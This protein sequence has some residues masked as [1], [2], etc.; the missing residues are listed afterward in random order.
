MR[1]TTRI[2][3]VGATSLVLGFVVAL[4]AL[5]AAPADAISENSQGDPPQVE[6][7]DLI[8]LDKFEFSDAGSGSFDNGTTGPDQDASEDGYQYTSS[9]G[10]TVAYDVDEDNETHSVTWWITADDPAVDLVVLKAGKNTPNKPVFYDEARGPETETVEGNAFSHITFCYDIEDPS[11]ELTHECVEG[12]SRITVTIT[13]PD[14]VGFEYDIEINDVVVATI[15]EAG[16]TTYDGADGDLLEVVND[17]QVLDELAFEDCSTPEEPEPT[18]ELSTACDDTQPTATVTIDNDGDETFEVE[19]FIDNVSQGT[20]TETT[21]FD[22]AAEGVLRAEWGDGESDNITFE[23]CTV[24]EPLTSVASFTVGT[25]C[26]TSL[27][28]L[29]YD[30]TISETADDPVGDI[31]LTV[32]DASG[33]LDQATFSASEA[34]S[35]VLSTDLEGATVTASW[36]FDDTTVEQQLASDCTDVLGAVDQRDDDAAP[37]PATEVK[38]EQLPNAGFEEDLL[39]VLAGAF[40]ALGCSLLLYGRRR[41]GVTA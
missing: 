38:G 20:I 21:T 5:L 19:V 2:R 36:D 30:A 14:D 32:S 40:I 33:E 26:Q 1:S 31:T 17:G 41:Y 27:P 34:G 28:A 16:S 6:C 4:L 24:D 11:V 7:G 22:G 37:L 25:E 3:P 39:L 10:V 15:T 13:N 9:T 18:V 12:T 23:D 8:Y 35:M 29:T